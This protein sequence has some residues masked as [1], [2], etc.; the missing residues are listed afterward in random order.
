M[1]YR[2]KTQTL[3]SWTLTHCFLRGK[4]LSDMRITCRQQQVHF[5]ERSEKPSSD[6]KMVVTKF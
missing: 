3:T 5:T 4:S 1:S 2:S 6:K